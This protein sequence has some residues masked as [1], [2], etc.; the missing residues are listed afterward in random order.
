MRRREAGPRGNGTR[1]TAGKGD[2]AATDLHGAIRKAL[3]KNVIKSISALN[4]C[5]RDQS[6]C[7][8]FDQRCGIE[9]KGWAGRS[10]NDRKRL[11]PQHSQAEAYSQTC[12]PW[13]LGKSQIRLLHLREC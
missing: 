10:V 12:R 1:S 6:V 13:S 3:K 9:R 11:K 7:K 4:A 2:R 5:E 8:D